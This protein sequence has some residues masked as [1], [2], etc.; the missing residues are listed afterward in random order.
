MTT[1]P[2]DPDKVLTHKPRTPRGGDQWPTHRA[3]ARKAR[4]G[5]TRP[6]G[7]AR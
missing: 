5:T 7:D 3:K 4:R 1:A 2:A 6:K